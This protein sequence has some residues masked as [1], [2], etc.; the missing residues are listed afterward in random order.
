MNKSLSERIRAIAEF[1][2]TE[3][4]TE[5]IASLRCGTLSPLGFAYKQGAEWEN[6]RL[7]PLIT[8]LAESCEALEEALHDIENKRGMCIF[9]SAETAEDPEVAFRQGSAYSFGET[10]EMAAEALTAHKKRMEGLK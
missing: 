9:G 6:D 7:T 5:G 1:N 3:A 2:P 8:A 4:Q 10:A